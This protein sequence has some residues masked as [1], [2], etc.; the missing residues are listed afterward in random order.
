[1]RVGETEKKLKFGQQK[2]T[3][4]EQYESTAAEHW[5]PIQMYHTKVKFRPNDMVLHLQVPLTLVA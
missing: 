3:Q 1:M 4:V 5:A 2:L